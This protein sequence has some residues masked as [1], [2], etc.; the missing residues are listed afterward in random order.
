MSL[1]VFLF[2][3]VPLLSICCRRRWY[4]IKTNE[5]N[6]LLYRYRNKKSSFLPNQLTIMP[7]KGGQLTEHIFTD[8]PMVFVPLIS[9]KSEKSVSQC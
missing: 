8:I 7:T 6:C 2:Y 9:E 3:L 5:G 1:K 4:M